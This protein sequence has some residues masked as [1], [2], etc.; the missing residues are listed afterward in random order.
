MRETISLIVGW[1]IGAFLG[2]FFVHN[3]LSIWVAAPF[4]FGGGFASTVLTMQ[5]IPRRH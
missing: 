2:V 5:F 1:T 4:I 3:G